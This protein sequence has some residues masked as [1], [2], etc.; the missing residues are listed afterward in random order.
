MTA[1]Q[2]SKSEANTAVAR[3]IAAVR[4]RK[5]L[6]PRQVYEP[7]GISKAT[8]YRLEKG[9]RDITI[10]YLAAICAVLGVSPSAVVVSAQAEHPEAFKSKRARTRLPGVRR[11][12]SSTQPRRAPRKD[13]ES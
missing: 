2:V 9:E 3:E 12:A 1:S 10:E 8:Y 13:T 7:A 5:N 6:D 11:K 4:A